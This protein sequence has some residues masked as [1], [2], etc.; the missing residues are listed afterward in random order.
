MLRLN[1]DLYRKLY[2]IRRAEEKIR[3]HYPE[4]EMKTP[5]HMSMGEEAIAV[6]ICHAIKAED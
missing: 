3:Q 1:L 2:L 4:N 6:G 5:M